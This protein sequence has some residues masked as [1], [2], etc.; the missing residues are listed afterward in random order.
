M[1]I[2]ENM[3]NLVVVVVLFFSLCYAQK[4]KKEKEKKEAFIISYMP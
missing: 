2:I 3:Q 1:F 4:G